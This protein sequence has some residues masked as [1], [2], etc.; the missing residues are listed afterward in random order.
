MREIIHVLSLGLEERQLSLIGQRL[1]EKLIG[2]GFVSRHKTKGLPRHD[3][4]ESTNNPISFFPR[5][6]FKHVHVSVIGSDG[7]EAQVF[8]FHGNGVEVYLFVN[9]VDNGQDLYKANRRGL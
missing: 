3:I 8:F 4:F 7:K 2:N 6:G 1:L 9:R 5:D